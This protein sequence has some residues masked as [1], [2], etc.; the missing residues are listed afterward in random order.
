MTQVFTGPPTI[1]TITNQV[2]KLDEKANL[3]C[4]ANG[5]GTITYQWQK[6]YKHKW[7]D[8][9]KGNTAQYKT[10]KLKQSS[11][12]RCVASNE[13]GNVASD[14]T[15]YVLSK[16]TLYISMSISVTSYFFCCSH[17][18]SPSRPTKS[19]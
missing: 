10:G 19:N 7:M 18:H 5:S 17:Y 6:L 11:Q 16:H 1:S 15:V 8:I 4:A 14:I 3:V 2:I 9:K 13:A 12:F